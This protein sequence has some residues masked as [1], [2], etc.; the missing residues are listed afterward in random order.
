ML[1]ENI[2]E[3]SGFI[4]LALGIGLTACGMSHLVK[5]NGNK[6]LGTL[7][8]TAG[9]LKIAEGIFLYC[10][11]KALFSSNVKDA[12]SSSIQKYM[13]GDSLMNAFNS[14]YANTG[15]SNRQS[16]AQSSSGHEEAKA[17]QA[18]AE[19]AEKVAS[20]TP[21]GTAANEAAK[22]VQAVAKNSNSK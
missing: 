11:T 22:T 9:A 14:R 19:V 7:I 21:A 18:A 1:E 5:E 3:K 2:S 20:S 4:R 10:P 16:Q 6:T 13:D 15:S 17:V 12:V 8:V